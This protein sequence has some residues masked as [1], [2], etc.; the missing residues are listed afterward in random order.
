LKIILKILTLLVAISL[1]LS[2]LSTYVSAE[3]L[4]VMP[5]FGLLFAPLMLMNVGLTVMWMV[6][7][8]WFFLLPLAAVV[9]NVGTVR[10]LMHFVSN[11][12]KTSASGTSTTIKMLSYN[13]NM[14]GARWQS[15]AATYAPVAKFIAREKFDIVCLQE[16]YEH[17]T[18][19]AAR[20]FAAQTAA[21]QHRHVWYSVARRGH[22]F[23][24]ATLSRY[25]IVGKGCIDFG[26]STNG[27]I[28][29]DLLLGEADTVRVYNVHLQS[30]HF[31]RRER[32]ALIDEH[33]W[34]D[35]KGDHREVLQKISGKLKTAFLKRAKQV[36][37]VSE[38]IRASP[39]PVVL[40]GD[41]NDT[42]VSYTYRTMRGDLR[43]GFIDAGRGIMS[44]YESWIP[45]F[46]IDY[47]LYHPRYVATA[48]YCPNHTYSD[49]Y[50]VVCI[51]RREE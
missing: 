33:F 10:T 18:S 17:D 32:S 46:R 43:D 39:H 5:F 38:H 34:L 27:A 9:L 42:P 37:L 11:D 19:R 8:R 21:L 31:G 13:V 41:F 4:W 7:R 24:L 22:H 6:M 12:G 47:V 35:S 36:D 40:C 51:L 1:V 29:T 44:T 28:Y 3:W 48:Y 50:P 2:R 45:S 30:N 25:P 14:F 23:G 49:H 15:T 16:Y 26:G 20:T